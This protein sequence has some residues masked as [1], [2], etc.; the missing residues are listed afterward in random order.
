M[1][2]VALYDGSEKA[3]PVKK[4]LYDPRLLG[5]W[6]SDKRRTSREIRA[7]R[8]LTPQQCARLVELFGH[9]TLQYTRARCR[10]TFRG[11]TESLP[12]RVVA[13]N[14]SGV[15]VVGPQMLVPGQETIQHIR[16]DEDARKPSHYWIALGSIREFFRRIE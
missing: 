15:V 7:R 3:E 5:T 6:R 11:E 1:T 4:N 14:S 13:K 9:L 16:F 8:D 10:S 2:G 12:Y